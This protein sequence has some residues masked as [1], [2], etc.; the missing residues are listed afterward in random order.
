NTT[1]FLCCF[2]KEAFFSS[3]TS[4]KQNMYAIRTI[5]MVDDPTHGYTN[6][7]YGI[8]LV[9][10]RYHG[11]IIPPTP[12][13][14]YYGGRLIHNYSHGNYTAGRHWSNHP[15]MVYMYP[16]FV[17]KFFYSPW[18]KAMQ[19]RKLQI[20]P[21]LSTHS[22]QHGL[23]THHLATL[24]TLEKKYIEFATSTTD[25]RLVPEYQV[26]FPNLCFPNY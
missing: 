24:D 10:Q 4:L 2:D 11:I 26:I 20:G 17:L 9:K 5:L 21:T 6:P 19:N 13:A 16:A 25:L 22:I 1:E 15:F 3:L 18:N 23:G 12:P 8:P 14:P 7:R